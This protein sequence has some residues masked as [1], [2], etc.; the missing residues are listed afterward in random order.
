M[1]SPDSGNQL[2]KLPSVAA[3]MTTGDLVDSSVIAKVTYLMA[4]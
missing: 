1:S 3:T 2:L 4:F